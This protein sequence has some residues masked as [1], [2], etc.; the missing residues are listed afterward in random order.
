MTRRR[1]A[2]AF[3][4][5]VLAV[6]C[7]EGPAREP[8]AKRSPTPVIE[9][10]PGAGVA[11]GASGRTSIRLRGAD[12]AIEQA[13]IGALLEAR[14][15]ALGAGRPPAY[16]ATAAGARR[17]S[18]AADA[19][20]ARA[21]GVRAVRIVAVGV[22]VR[23]RRATASTRVSYRLAGVAGRWTYGQRLRLRRTGRGWRVVGLRPRPP[24]PPWEL[25]AYQRFDTRHFTVFTPQ[26]IDPRSADLDATLE[27]AY[28]TIGE[29]LPGRLRRRYPVLIAGDD[30]DM[31][32]MTSG[33]RDVGRLSAITDLSLR[34][35][36]PAERVTALVGVRI[37]VPWPSFVALPSAGRERVLTHE[38]AHAVLAPATSGR[39]PAWLQEGIALYVSGDRRTDAARTAF[40]GGL[41]PPASRLARLARPDAMAALAG[42]DLSAAY[43]LSSSTAYY[44]AER[45]R[46]Q[47]LLDLLAA[48]GDESL[49]GRAGRS[50]TDRAVRRV[51]GIGARRLEADVAE[52]VLDG[53]P[54]FGG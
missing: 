8:S 51:L 4:L 25:A 11:A 16:A 48:F 10:R 30:G 46:P 40:T 21:L 39:A 3:A 27:R 49:P 50:L 38:L 31:A 12:M 41:A 28:A 20:R 19:R 35:A 23:G 45:Y 14:A 36:G 37:L 7:G 53:A 47:A 9:P 1:T 24:R 42:E 32:A 22:R 44:V 5:A 2:T 17:R 52:W 26:G 29:R 33:I 18:D 13:A 6:G 54:G 34:T 43:A 15:D